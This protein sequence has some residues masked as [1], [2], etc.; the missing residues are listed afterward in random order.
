MISDIYTSN[1]HTNISVNSGTSCPHTLVRAYT[2]HTDSRSGRDRVISDISIK[3]RQKILKG[4]GNNIS[5]HTHT[6]LK[7]PCDQEI[8]L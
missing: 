6:L 4:M 5:T 3:W 8:S 2:H 1:T 7:V